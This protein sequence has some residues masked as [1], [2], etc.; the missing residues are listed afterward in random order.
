MEKPTVF[1][2]HGYNG[3]PKIFS[4]FKN[5][6][7]KNGH[8]VILPSFPTQTA[9]TKNSYF[10]VFDQYK[11]ELNSNTILI[12]HSIGNILAIKYLCANNINIRGYISLAGFGEPFVHKDRDDLNSVI[13]P[14]RLTDEEIAI[15]PSLIKKSYSIYSD[16]DHVVPFDILKKYP[17][18]I[19]AKECLIP[20]VGHMGSKSGLEEFPK[21]IELVDNL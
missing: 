11:N 16:N 21:V 6:L 8:K 18:L 17:K 3:I 20:G 4:Y 9:I 13:A 10:A 19:G 14:L 12:A 2:V 1:L 5:T 7:E 15:I